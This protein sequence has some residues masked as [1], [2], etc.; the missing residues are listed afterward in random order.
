MS[1]EGKKKKNCEPKLN[2]IS[3]GQQWKHGHREET[4][5]HSTGRRGRDELGEQHWNSYFTRWKTDSLW[6]FAVRCRELNPMLSNNLKG[7]DGVGGGKGGLRGRRHTYTYG[8]FM[9]TYGRN[10]HNIVKQLS[11]NQKQ[12]IFSLKKVNKPGIERNFLNLVKNIYKKLSWE[13]TPSF[14]LLFQKFYSHLILCSIQG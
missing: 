8:W 10:Q 2:V 1:G 6:E 5:G 9:L 12:I 3:A 4:G 11:F 14:V 13:S 7:W